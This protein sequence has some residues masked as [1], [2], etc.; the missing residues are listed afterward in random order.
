M[1]EKRSVGRPA[2]E[3]TKVLAYRVP[4]SISGE[5]DNEVKKV[6]NKAKQS[7]PKSYTAELKSGF[8]LSIKA[9]NLKEAKAYASRITRG[10]DKIISV[11]LD[12]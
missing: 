8:E 7:L 4:E 1:K 2:K 6:I 5:V 12:K 10:N 3:P 11:T 9:S